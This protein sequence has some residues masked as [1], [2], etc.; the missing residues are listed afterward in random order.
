[1]RGLLTNNAFTGFLLASLLILLPGL[2]SAQVLPPAAYPSTTTVNYKRTWQAMAPDQVPAHLITRPLT[3]VVQTT[4]YFDGMG[5][6]QQTVVKQGSLVTNPASPSSYATATDLVGTNIYD[7]TGRETYSYLPFAMS[8]ATSPDVTNDGNFKLSP[9]QQQIAFFNTQL[10]GQTGE[11]NVGS[12]GLNWAYKKNNYEATP[13]N[14]VLSALA[15]G[16]NWVGS[17]GTS[18]AHEL[19]NGYYI[20]TTTDNVQE[21]SIAMAQGSLPVRSTAYPAG[22][23]YK[24]ITTNERGVQTIEYRDEDDQ[25][26]LSKVQLTAAT[27]N[28]TGSAHAGWLC[29]YYVYDDYGNMRFIIT[30]HVVQAI[31]GTWSIAQTSADALCYRFEYDQINRIEIK[32]LPGEGELWIVYDA[33]NRPIMLQDANLRPTNQWWFIKYDGMDRMVVNGLVTDNVNT[34]LAAQ[35]AA[36]TAAAL[37]L[38][39]Q[40]TT[41][42]T[43]AYTLTQ[44]Y[45]AVGTANVLQALYYDDYGWSSNYGSQFAA[46][47]NTYDA[48]FPAANNSTYPYPQPLTQAPSARGRVTGLWAKLQGTYAESSATGI[49]RS[50]YYDNQGQT[51]Q[52]QDLNI[53]GGTDVSTVQ[54][55]WSGKPLQIVSVNQKAGTN[56]QTYTM[57]STMTYDP[58]WRLLTST[59]AV[60]GTVNG[61]AV[62]APAQVVVSNQYDAQGH[63]KNKALGSLETLAYDYNVRNWPLG[64]NR[65]YIGGAPQP[66]Y[67]GL[68]L[69]YDNSASAGGTTTY[70]AQQY[71]GNLAGITW[72]SAGDGIA[73]KYDFTYDFDDRLQGANFLQN[74]TGST[75]DQNLLNFSVSGIGYD[76]NGNIKQMMQYGYLIGQSGLIDN[77]TYTYT[78]S[79]NSNQLQQVFDNANNPTSTL[80]DLHYTGSK[81]VGT[82]TDYTY[83]PNGNLS[84]DANKGFTAITYNY[85]NLPLQIPVTGKGT[86]SYVYDAIGNRLAKVTVDNATGLK[87]TTTYIGQFI[88]QS[89]VHNPTVAGDVTD[90]LQSIENQEGRIR[91]IIPSTF[92]GNKTF[93]FDYYIKDHL[94]NPRMVL[95]DEK[96]QDLNIPAATFEDGVAG[97][98]TTYYSVA[99]SANII[100]N[101]SIPGGYSTSVASYPNNNGIT[102]PDTDPNI[103]TSSASGHMYKLPAGS[104]QPTDLGITIKVT[105]GDMVSLYGKSYYFT[106]GVTPTNN[107]LIVNALNGF[108]G[109]FTGT[110]NIVNGFGHGAAT[111][112]T[113]LETSNNVL[114]TSLQSALQGMPQAGTGA[115]RA[116]LNWILFD[117][118]LNAVASN[119]SS[120]QVGIVASGVLGNLST[121]VTVSKSGYLYVY[122]SNESSNIDVY[123]DN[124]QVVNNRGPIM[125]ETHYYPFGL[126][127]AA[128]SSLGQNKPENKFKFNEGSE[129]QHHEFSDGSGLELYDATYR[130]YDPQIGR[131]N[132][133]DRLAAMNCETSPYA[134]VKN[135]PLLFSDRLGL[136]SSTPGWDED[137]ETVDDSGTGSTDSQDDIP[138]Q[139][140]AAPAG[141][142]GVN[143]VTGLIYDPKTGKIY[144]DPNIN[145]QSDLPK[146]TSLVFL[147]NQI[148]LT[149]TSGT[150]VWFEAGK[151]NTINTY[152]ENPNWDE[153]QPVVVSAVMREKPAEPPST[154]DKVATITGLTAD[155]YVLPLD[156]AKGVTKAAVE[157]VVEKTM[158]GAT[159]GGGILSAGV[160][161]KHFIDGHGTW[162]DG[163]AIGLAAASILL[164]ASPAGWIWTA[165]TLV[166]DGAMIVND[167]WS[168]IDDIKA[169][170]KSGA[171]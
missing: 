28:G 67:F 14:R 50:M 35:I 22:S 30:P 78:N 59:R 62:T 93:A 16:A 133:I 160:A 15:P 19:Q 51:V 139:T 99:N 33:R 72:K 161:T 115:P 138:D 108:V 37:G 29:T 44:S 162:H 114:N 128:I 168:A 143:A 152:Y 167:T 165:A 43:I 100:P 104:T 106:N 57:S 158:W 91:P 46:K 2:A 146:N 129:F 131:F 41:A 137:D 83:D 94:G 101:A 149:N 127:I 10:S 151:G 84:T 170:N 11:T 82:S 145:S 81:T 74:T 157:G 4:Q 86:I 23:L 53:T 26:I 27:D 119:S 125:E 36:M 61:A 6:S 70:A 155:S 130:L 148:A 1:M 32:K 13:L 17:E 159:I 52:V 110:G 3:D 25:L 144:N 34:T 71:G 103:N 20:N 98:L 142:D 97:T 123:F 126:T 65:Q 56:A 90:G 85:L 60:S 47:N 77:L 12:S 58:E 120:I 76:A 121:S 95:T 21:W 109:A 124:L 89:Q 153:L 134:F 163:L 9:F 164:L 147:G 118:Q 38:Y 154:L 75:W 107:D 8:A 166:V 55:S 113:A 150:T 45:P 96:Q 116:G 112:A 42:N 79:N 68:D 49:A 87:T 156:I 102:N 7:A 5:R 80:G 105:A 141:T 39:E 135:N 136:D 69:G 31:D 92:N 66:H 169:A 54:Y 48:Q 111:A 63:L 24:T 132:G 18:A 171:H 117:N 64:F 122:C 40:R 140:S 73:R 88:Y